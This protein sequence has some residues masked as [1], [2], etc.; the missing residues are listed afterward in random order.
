MKIKFIVGLIILILIVSCKTNKIVEVEVPSSVNIFETS[1]LKGKWT[2]DYILPVEGKEIKQLYKI[3]MPYLNFVDETKVAGNNGCNNISGGYSISADH[4]IHF[5]AEKFA[6]TRMFC[7]GLDE[8]TF[9]N[10]LKSVNKFD[11]IDNG[12]KL[13]LIKGDIVALS[14]VKTKE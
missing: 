8:K 4:S 6:A 11:V 3:Q 14:F 10:A 12:N 1:G 5:D 2:L 7:E 13:V 9:L